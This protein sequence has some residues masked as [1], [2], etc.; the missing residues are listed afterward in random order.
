MTRKL[1]FSKHTI[2]AGAPEAVS[3]GI[4]DEKTCEKTRSSVQIAFTS[5]EAPVDSTVEAR[6]ACLISNNRVWA[7]DEGQCLSTRHA[8]LVCRRTSSN[9]VERIESAHVDIRPQTQGIVY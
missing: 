8:V 7:V 6:I 5:R 1:L 4:Q 2:R 9:W 3:P